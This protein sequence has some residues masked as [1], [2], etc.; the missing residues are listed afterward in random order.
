MSSNEIRFEQMLTAR[1]V[2][3][4]YITGLGFNNVNRL[5]HLEMKSLGST[6]VPML[7]SATA[8]SLGEMYIQ[9]QKSPGVKFVEI[10]FEIYAPYG[11]SSAKT[12]TIDLGLPAGASFTRTP[13][14]FNPAVNQ[15]ERQIV[16]YAVD[17][18]ARKTVSCIVDVRSCVSTSV[19]AFTA[20]WTAI[21]GSSVASTAHGFRTI[22]MNERPNLAELSS[23]VEEQASEVNTPGLVIPFTWGQAGT[24][25]CDAVDNRKL[26]IQQIVQGLDLN[27]TRYRNQLNIASLND[28]GLNWIYKK[29]YDAF[30]EGNLVYGAGTSASQGYNRYFYL[31]AKNTYGLSVTTCPYTVSVIYS[32]TGGT[33]PY[34]YLKYRKYTGGAWSK[35][36]IQLTPSV[37]NKTL[38]TTVDLPTDGTDQMV[39]CYLTAL[40]DDPGTTIYIHNFWMGENIT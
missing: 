20:S 8:V 10:E 3:S 31:R 2:N 38:T 18:I 1:P 14:I 34:L 6:M 26:G 33:K 21:T 7:A 28:A 25:I 40:A 12:W 24:D 5:L 27:R 36:E 9:Y 19:L 16:P 32:V 39:E 29:D 35:L 37:S 23:G 30:G 17:S 13:N 11:A 4:K 15:T 22:T